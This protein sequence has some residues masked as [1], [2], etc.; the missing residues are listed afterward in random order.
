MNGTHLKVAITPVDPTRTIADLGDDED[1]AV[2]LQGPKHYLLA[3]VEA[4]ASFSLD[5]EIET[6][7]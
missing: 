6:L 4:L 3:I 7:L 1:L 2:V 5:E